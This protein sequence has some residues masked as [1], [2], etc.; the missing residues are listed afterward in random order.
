MPQMQ[1]EQQRLKNA[2]ASP[3]YGQIPHS[4]KLQRRE[5]CLPAHL[6][7]ALFLLRQHRVAA[8]SGLGTGL[9][10]TM[11]YFRHTTSGAVGNGLGTMIKYLRR[12]KNGTAGNGIGTTITYLRQ[13]TAVATTWPPRP[14]SQVAPRASTWA[15]RSST[16]PSV[17]A[18]SLSFRLV[19]INTFIYAA[20]AV[21]VTTA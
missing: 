10:T 3:I 13:A 14:S 2:S 1:L 11:K 12:T 5:L 15:P 18:R 20:G 6:P 19:L 9:G 16:V 4:S 21:G 17:C 8:G 7:S